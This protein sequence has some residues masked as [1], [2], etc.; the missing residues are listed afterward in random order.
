MYKPCINV[1]IS[2][3]SRLCEYVPIV[4]I[5]HAS[6][7]VNVVLPSQRR[8]RRYSNRGSMSWLVLVVL[9]QCSQTPPHAPIR[10]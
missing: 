3:I 9:V 4:G 6:A 1:T 2:L 5:D 8:P 10:P 7:N